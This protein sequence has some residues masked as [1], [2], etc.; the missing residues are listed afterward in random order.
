MN[1]RDFLETIALK[2][3]AYSVPLPDCALTAL[4]SPE[5]LKE[6]LNL[7]TESEIEDLVRR[8]FLCLCRKEGCGS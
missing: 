6:K 1:A 3:P 7:L 4:H 2:C 5:S 8:H